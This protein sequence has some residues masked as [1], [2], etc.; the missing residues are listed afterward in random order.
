[1]ANFTLGQRQLSFEEV[2]GRCGYCG[3]DLEPNFEM[4]HVIPQSASGTGSRKRNI[5]AA[6]FKC[7]RRKRDH[8]LDYLKKRM[9][10][11]E[12]WFEQLTLCKGEISVPVEF[13][14]G[15]IVSQS[16]RINP[17]VWEK[18][19]NDRKNLL[20]MFLPTQGR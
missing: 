14:F 4:D 7:N 13:G 9:K 3:N 12:F 18:R 15:I 8:G 1:M 20:S 6:C 19:K 2:E 17:Y 5:L 10:I 16:V 11:K